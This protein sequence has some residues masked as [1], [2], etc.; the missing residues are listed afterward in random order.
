MKVRITLFLFLMTS[1]AA[2]S[3]QEEEINVAGLVFLDYKSS[4]PADFLGSKTV[5]LVGTP[6]IPGQSIR[7]D[8]KEMVAESHIEFYR[9]GIDAVG[10]YNYEDVIAGPESRKAFSESW[11]KREI[12]YV[13][14][15]SKV[16]VSI[17]NKP[18]ERFVIMA[19]KFN[20]LPS[21]MSDGQE[22]WKVQGK[23]LD[24]ALKKM[25][26]DAARIG[27][28]TVLT[29]IDPEYFY[30]APMVR[31]QHVETYFTDLDFGKMAVPQFEIVEI[32]SN[33]P[34]GVINNQVEK[35]ATSANEKSAQNNKQLA[36]LIKN[37][38]F[39]YEL[40]DPSLTDEDLIKQGFMYVMYNLRTSGKS[41]KR[42]LDYDV[43]DDDETYMTVTEVKGKPTL[44]YIPADA[45]VY[46]YYIK[47][48][49]TGNVYLGKTW[50]ADETWQDALKN[51]LRTINDEKPA[52]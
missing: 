31:G 17:K 29:N 1:V 37:Y 2:F 36:E 21:L 50:D 47:H 45:P 11:K 44:R 13:M 27:G 25:A 12:E 33:R 40:T 41:I 43:S 14:V 30:D 8:Y 22:A 26:K 35:Q 48:L 34:G 18:S 52:K 46:K 38:K 32:P 6:P 9:A 24:A 7:Q 49:R 4:M 10:Y 5:V 39:R 19:T 16:N 20:N 15:L 3:Q 28:K 23:K 42:L 51:A